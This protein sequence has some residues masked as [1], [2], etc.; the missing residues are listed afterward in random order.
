MRFRNSFRLLIDNFRNVYKL[1]LFF[2]ATYAVTLIIAGRF[3][4]MGLQY[5][6]QSH[7]MEVFLDHLKNIIPNIVMNSTSYEAFDDAIRVTL[8]GVAESFGSLFLLARAK[9]DKIIFSVIAIVFVYI[10]ARFLN[11]LALFAFGAILND[12]MSIYSDT[13]FFSAFFSNLGKAAI[14]QIVYVPLAVAYDLLSIFA[15]YFLFFVAF[16]FLPAIVGLL[17]CVTFVMLAQAFKLS[18]IS[19][20]MP[21]IIVDGKKM[22]EAIK[23]MFTGAKGRFAENFSNFLMACYCIVA[24][25]VLFALSSF[26]SALICT[27]PASFIFLICLQFVNYYTSNNRKYF[28]TYKHICDGDNLSQALAIEQA[29]E[30]QKQEELKNL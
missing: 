7:E 8:G 19:E 28:L 30:L 23:G 10:L 2:L 3:L 26:G 13:P 6:L 25:N 27:V 4:D 24:V 11:G 12:K 14:Y 5:L 1:L 18:V 22:G 20:W 29:D 17:I 21:A 9:I 15:A 16:D